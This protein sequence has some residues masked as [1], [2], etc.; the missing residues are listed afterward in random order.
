MNLIAVVN[1]AALLPL[2]AALLL[3]L[4]ALYARH[5]HQAEASPGPARCGRC[6]RCGRYVGHGPGG[7][8][9]LHD[10]TYIYISHRPILTGG[11]RYDRRNT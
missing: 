8:V 3:Y 2:I 11:P 6:A 5:R 7:L 1:G 9:H 4:L 10:G